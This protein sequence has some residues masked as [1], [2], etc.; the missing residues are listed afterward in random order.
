MFT[1]D[2]ATI[3]STGA[4]LVGE[5]ERMDQTLNMPLV[6]YKWSRD[7]PLRSDISIADEVSSFTNTD[8]LAL[9]VQTL[10]VKTGS[11]KKLQPFLVS[12]S[13]FSL[14]VTTSPCGGRKSAGQ[15]RNWLLLRN[16]AVRLM[17]R[18]TKA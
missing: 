1:I 18:N 13:I 15:C 7:M 10:T 12:N 11:V 3:D 2:R 5:L 4:F 17:S 6:S 9:V 16:W 8:L 14:P